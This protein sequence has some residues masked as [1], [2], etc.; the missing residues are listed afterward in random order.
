[1]RVRN[2]DRIVRVDGDLAALRLQAPRQLIGKVDVAQ[3][4]ARVRQS[5]VV[6]LRRRPAQIGP[7]CGGERGATSTPHLGCGHVQE[8]TE[9]SAPVQTPP[10]N[11]LLT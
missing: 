3:L 4:G 11:W 1:M 7:G 9:Q 8:N 5:A 6:L 2:T 10:L